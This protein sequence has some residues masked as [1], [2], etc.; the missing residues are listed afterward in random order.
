MDK[1]EQKRAFD[2]DKVEEQSRVNPE[3]IAFKYER[4]NNMVF[5]RGGAF[6]MGTDL[7]IFTNDGEA[8]ARRVSL[9][10]Y[11]MDVHEVSNVEFARFVA[12]TGHKTEAENFGDSFAMDY[13]LSP[14]TLESIEKAVKAAPWWLPVPGAN[15]RQPEGKDSSIVSEETEAQEEDEDFVESKTD[16]MTHPVIHVSWNDAAAFCKWAGKRLPTEAE[17]EYACRA[18]KRGPTFSL[19]K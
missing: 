11:Y 4:K 7:P 14:K 18:K 8:P 19:G 15:W 9:S 13:F 2:I 1:N 12:E 10:S 16:R 6:T 3:T 5:I 17:W